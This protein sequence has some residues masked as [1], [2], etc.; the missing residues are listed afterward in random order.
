MANLITI[1]AVSNK[2][3]SRLG[4]FLAHPYPRVS[5][6]IPRVLNMFVTIRRGLNR[7]GQILPNT[8]TRCC[9][10]LIHWTL[11]RRQRAFCWKQSGMYV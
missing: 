3:I 6:Q 7:S 8:Y 5:D 1:Q 2:A 11:K 10:A 9:K 4:D